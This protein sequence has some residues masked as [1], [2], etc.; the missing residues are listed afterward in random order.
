ML[1][2]NVINVSVYS[3][4]PLAISLCGLNICLKFCDKGVCA[5]PRPPLVSK[6]ERSLVHYTTYA[7]LIRCLCGE[8]TKVGSIYESVS[9]SFRTASIT[10]YRLTTLNTHWK[11]TQKVI[12]TK[13]TK[14]SHRIAIQL[15][16]VEG[17]CTIC[18]SRSRRPVRKL[19]D[20]PSFIMFISTLGTIIK[21]ILGRQDRSVADQWRILVNTMKTRDASW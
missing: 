16:L 1:C 18:S 10:K 12:A 2:K 17:S 11:A 20:T 14:L 15:H 7:Q 4:E 6:F 21:W 8:K 3:S 9:K 13:P 19:L 5:P